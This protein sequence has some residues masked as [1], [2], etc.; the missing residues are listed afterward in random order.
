MDGTDLRPI[1]T[2]QYHASLA[3]LRQAVSG[4][5]SSLWTSARYTN[6]FWHIAYHTLFF[7]HLY[8]QKDEASFKPW[9]H[10]RPE[11][12]FMGKLPWPPH[13]YPR[14]GDPYTQ[15]EVLDYWSFCEAMVD[16]AVEQLDLSAADCGF[17]WY[18]M[19]KLEHQFNSIRHVQHHTGQL[20]DRLRTKADFAV[21]WIGG[22]QA[23]A[24]AW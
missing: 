2:S 23:G 24:M 15:T 22:R 10:S 14:I 5:P 18:K 11:Y 21:E 12:Q 1:L 17:R 3:M 19:S 8:L 9:K 13:D 4:C 6:T 16:G 7:T 20:A